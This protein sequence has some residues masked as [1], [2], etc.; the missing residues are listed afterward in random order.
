MLNSYYNFILYILFGIL[1]VLEFFLFS[2]WKILNCV[3]YVGVGFLGVLQFPL[4]SKDM[5]YRGIE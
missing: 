1:I 4:K 5:H 3:I 2:G